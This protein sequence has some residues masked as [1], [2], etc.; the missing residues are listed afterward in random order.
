[1]K[2]L[3]RNPIIDLRPEFWRDVIGQSKI[4]ATLKSM[5]ERGAVPNGI[6]FTGGMGSGKTTL[7]RLVVKATSC[8]DRNGSWEPC[9]NCFFCKALT[10]DLVSAGSRYYCAGDKLTDQDFTKLIQNATCGTL[11]G[12][13]PLAA[14]F[15]DDLDSFP[16][17]QQLI[18]RTALD[19]TWPRGYLVATTANPEKIDEPLRQRMMQITV[20]PPT[21]AEL[22]AW[23]QNIITNNLGLVIQDQTAL[24][25]LMLWGKM[26]FR[27][28]LKILTALYAGNMPV[29]MNTVT[30]A[31]QQCGFGLQ[32]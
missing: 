16:K 2:T 32:Q 25:R 1:M 7:A 27:S 6:L 4:L 15:I 21:Q 24:L 20:L 13:S 23:L 22:M 12:E 31:A 17:S 9:G 14:L 26:N 10:G 19:K 18:L 3:I 29:N 28:I 5:I 8:T 30:Q 11:W